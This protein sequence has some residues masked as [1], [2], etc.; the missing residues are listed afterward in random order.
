MYFFDLNGL[1]EHLKK[2]DSG[3][4]FLAIKYLILTYV[5]DGLSETI[6]KFFLGEK[7]SVI[8]PYQV[9]ILFGG[10]LGIGIGALI[11]SYVLKSFYEA[12]YGR[13][14]FFE[15]LISIAFVVGLR[16]AIPFTLFFVLFSVSG[17][18]VGSMFSAIIL[19][20]VVIFMIVYFYT[21]VRQSLERLGA[22]DATLKLEQFNNE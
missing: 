21:T 5:L 2:G 14:N 12:N 8:E 16:V 7:K 4:T 22:H 19:L 17:V 1:I 10:A 20:S 11:T 9:S 15:R 18:L 6:I 3:D 13:H